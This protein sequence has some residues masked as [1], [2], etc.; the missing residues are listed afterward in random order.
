MGV[1]MDKK[2][3]SG[4]PVKG[5]SL[6]MTGDEGEPL[7]NIAVQ[8]GS[9]PFWKTTFFRLAFPILIVEAAERLCFY[10]IQ[11]NL[12]HYL[13]NYMGFDMTTSIMFQ[14]VFQFVGYGSCI[15]MGVLSDMFWGRKRTIF[16]VSLTY[17]LAACLIGVSA[18]P[19]FTHHASVVSAIS[20]NPIG[21]GLYIAGMF[22][23]AV[24][25]GG[26]KSNVSA[27]GAD[28]FDISDA[29]ERKQLEAF[30]SWFYVMI[31]MGGL[32][33]GFFP[34][35]MQAPDPETRGYV[36]GYFLA[37]GFMF[38]AFLVY[39]SG[40]RRY[41]EKDN[42]TNFSDFPLLFGALT[43]AVKGVFVGRPSRKLEDAILPT[44]PLAI[45]ED[46]HSEMA[47]Q[48]RVAQDLTRKRMDNWINRKAAEK[49]SPPV[50]ADAHQLTR[51]LPIFL[52][53]TCFVLIYQ[54]IS[55]QFIYQ[56]EQMNNNGG[57]FNS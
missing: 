31:Q 53:Y 15:F 28:Q 14:S 39:V 40:Y 19:Q 47:I 3:V 29:S 33:A 41:R 56:G 7:E 22:C 25:M 57:F 26:V 8:N 12:A 16:W 37:A 42:H 18:L 52:S 17:A 55:D 50:C 30:F 34:S 35:F 36:L 20:P 13:L 11:T 4:G 6:S 10:T 5:I 27:F 1:D 32:T 24:C 46:P 44:V 2:D 54:M 51:T 21:Q 38:F 49:Y 48:A 23:L 43:S 9:P 45:T